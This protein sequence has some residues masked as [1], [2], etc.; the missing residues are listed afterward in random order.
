MDDD[1]DKSCLERVEDAW[2][3]RREDL[4]ALLE[5]RDPET[6]EEDED[7]S[8]AEYGLAFDYV[9]HGTFEDQWAGYF[10]YQLSYGGPSEEFRFYCD[11]DYKP[12]K[13]EFWL[14]DWFD[15]AHKNITDDTVARQVWEWFAEID[16]PRHAVEHAQ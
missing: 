3:S 12:F 16:A 1:R 4:E 13:I 8:L 15:G 14:L 10:R 9:P 5:G 6:G 2:F 7:A 11:P